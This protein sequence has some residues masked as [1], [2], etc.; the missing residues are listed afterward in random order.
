MISH[1]TQEPPSPARS[2]A[3]RDLLCL[4]VGDGEFVPLCLSVFATFVFLFLLEHGIAYVYRPSLRPLVLAA[5]DMLTPSAAGAVRPEPVERLQYLLGLLVTPLFLFFA[6]WKARAQY[7]R[8][9]AGVRRILNYAAALLLLGGTIALPICA[10]ESLKS[11]QFLYVRASVLH[12]SFA[13]YTAVI[14]P[15]IATLALLAH[16]RWVARLARWAIYS[17]CACVAIVAFL[18]ALLNRETALSWMSHLD[19]VLYPLAQV[20]AGK[21]LLVNCAPLYGLYPHLLQPLFSIIPLSVYYFTVVMAFLLVTSLIAQWLFLRLLT[22][23][24]I[25]LLCGIIAI[26]FFA[27]WTLKTVSADPYFQYWPIR[28]LFPSLLL[29]LS[30]LY[31]RGRATRLVYYGAFLCASL[32][33]LWNPDSGSVVF[34][35][36]VL[37]LGYRELFRNPLQNVWRPLASHALTASGSLLLVLG[38]YA[39]FARAR[40]GSW[41]DL[42]M[43]SSYYELFSHYGYFMLP[44]AGLPHVWGLTVGIFVL[45]LAISLH[46]LLRKMDEPFHASLFLLAI[47]GSGL[48]G[49]YNGRSHDYCVTF[50]L[51]VPILIVTLL[52][53]RVFTSLRSNSAYLKLLPLTCVLFFFPASALPS[54]FS[55]LNVGWFKEVS[56][57][58]MEA[59]HYSRQGQSSLNIDFIK[60]LTRPGESIFILIKEWREGSYYAESATRSALDLPSSIDWFFKR[61]YAEIDR[62]LRENKSVKVFAIPRQFNE[63]TGALQAYRVAA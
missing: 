44:M 24:N 26:P 35:A 32:A 13:L 63:F 23:N 16:R 21:T 4:L 60:G 36:W 59:S 39:V 51:Y 37:L 2:P 6:L 14:F 1:G 17:A 45:A 48:F 34:G 55:P 8:T 56:I 19:P 30:A 58:G 27:H 52:V 46:G 43:S 31:L 50:W 57:A 5:R 18:G 15:A 47:L 25:A 54:L 3:V 40:S 28:T 61:D 38:G 20:H 10:Y 49:Y 22:T 41:P 29:L 33:I 53:D 12:T 42:R 11:S 62:F 7:W 9:S